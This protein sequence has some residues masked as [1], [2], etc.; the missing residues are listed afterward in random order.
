MSMNGAERNGAMAEK[1][2]QSKNAV[3]EVQID[4]PVLEE[5][6]RRTLQAGPGTA[7]T[8]AEL[9]KL[10]RL[11]VKG[12]VKSLRGL[13]YAENLSEILLS[14]ALVEDLSP[15]YEMAMGER[16][17]EKERRPH[18]IK[19]KLE[20]HQAQDVAFLE[21]IPDE[22]GVQV[23]LSGQGPVVER[24]FEKYCTYA[25]VSF[26]RNCG[27]CVIYG[28]CLLP[29][30]FFEDGT[31]SY[32]S[33]NERAV[34]VWGPFFGESVEIKVGDCAGKA[35]ITARAGNSTKKIEVLVS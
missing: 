15:L 7:I 32:T 18:L 14:G 26:V 8:K 31:I 30:L 16:D 4:D 34:K 2:R 29:W 13:E 10:Q 28:E 5:E 21:R 25:P 27:D 17:G 6:L 19:I 22:S 9:L 11:Q 35:V 12:K 1:G 20:N 33:H 24:A 23:Y 3:T